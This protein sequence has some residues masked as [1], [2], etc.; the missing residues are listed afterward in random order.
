MI[1][2]DKYIMFSPDDYG[3][4]LLYIKKLE[5]KLRGSNNKSSMEYNISLELKKIIKTSERLILN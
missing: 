5:K 1:D 4:I 2:T 3:L